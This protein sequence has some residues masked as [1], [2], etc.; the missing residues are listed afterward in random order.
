MC[1]GKYAENVVPLCS[2]NSRMLR[3]CI[4]LQDADTARSTRYGYIEH[5]AKDFLLAQKTHTQPKWKWTMTNGIYCDQ[6][7]DAVK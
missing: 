5:A 2:Q 1:D 3:Q 4:L 7:R 6:W